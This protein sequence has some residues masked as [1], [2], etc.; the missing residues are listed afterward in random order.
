M[1][2]VSTNIK[3]EPDVKEQAQELFREFG[4]SLST[5]VNIFLKQSIREHAI[6][7]RV[8]DPFYSPQNTEYLEK[9]TQEIDT[10]KSTLKEHKLLEV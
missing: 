2:T 10:G 7:F 9:V 1:S 8:Y 5:A 3:I 6:P 4:M